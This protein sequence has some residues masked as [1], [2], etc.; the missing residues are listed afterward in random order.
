MIKIVIKGKDIPLARGAKPVRSILYVITGISVKSQARN[1]KNS[2]IEAANGNVLMLVNKLT[3]YKAMVLVVITN[4][5]NV[6]TTHL[7]SP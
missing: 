5:Q 4:D 3:T 1:M 6:I 7:T 2:A